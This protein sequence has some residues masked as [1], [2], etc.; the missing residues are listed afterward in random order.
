M[1]CSYALRESARPT[2]YVCDGLTRKKSVNADVGPRMLFL[3]IVR[4]GDDAGCW[5]T[6]RRENKRP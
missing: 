3:L 2:A 6:R 1:P 4:G 5:R